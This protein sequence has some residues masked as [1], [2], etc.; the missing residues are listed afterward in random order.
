MRFKVKEFQSKEVNQSEKTERIFEPGSRTATLY[1]ERAKKQ[2][3]SG[4]QVNG[5]GKLTIHIIRQKCK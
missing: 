3:P 5:F 4:Y 1:Q 2:E